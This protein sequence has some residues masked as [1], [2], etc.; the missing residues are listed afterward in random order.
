M[1][2]VWSFQILFSEAKLNG[3]VNP[4][5]GSTQPLCAIRVEERAGSGWL[6]GTLLFRD[7]R[8]SAMSSG[9]YVGLAGKQNYSACQKCT[10][11]SSWP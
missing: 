10:V 9:V 6:Q 4:D 1:D 8:T 7:E 5:Q 2:F 3:L 11:F